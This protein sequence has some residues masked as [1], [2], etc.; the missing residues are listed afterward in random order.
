M[1]GTTTDTRQSQG[2]LKFGADDTDFSCQIT[3][4][5]INPSVDSTDSIEVLCGNKVGGGSTTNDTLE[6]TL[7][8]DYG[9]AAAASLQAF[10]WANRGKTVDFEWQ[11]TA[12]AATKW[13]GT[14]EVQALQVGGEVGQQVTVQGTWP[15]R[16]ITPPTGFGTGG[17]N[18]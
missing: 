11:P 18:P 17:L 13:A 12:D 2:I 15:I 16:S 14:V 5:S 9:A 3:A 6:F 10:S 1:A 7:I 8:S 4:C